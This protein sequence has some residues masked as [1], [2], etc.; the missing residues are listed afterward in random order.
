MNKK[1]FHCSKKD[2]TCPKRNQCQRYIDS[3]KEGARSTTLFKVSCTEENERKLYMKVEEENE[4]NIRT[5]D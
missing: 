1:I 2:N 3:D 5:E 4:S